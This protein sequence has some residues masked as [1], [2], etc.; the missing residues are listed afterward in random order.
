VPDYAAGVNVVRARVEGTVYALSG[1]CAHMACPLSLGTLDGYTLMCACHDWRFD[2]RTGQFLDAP[3]IGVPTYGVTFEEFF[4]ERGIPFEYIDYDLADK[5]AQ[6]RIMREL[7]AA[8]ADKFPF[9][10][11]GN[12]IVE[13][14]RPGRYAQLLGL[15]AVA[16]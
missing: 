2:V 5:T 9:V 1:S 7:D 16:R 4:A 11:I 6:D 8:G 15:S 14:Y 13:G 10:K 12:Q 3:E